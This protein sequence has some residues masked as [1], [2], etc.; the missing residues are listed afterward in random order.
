METPHVNPVQC[1]ENNWV[2]YLCSSP[3]P[4]NAVFVD[5]LVTGERPGIPSGSLK[6]PVHM[7]GW[8][9]G[10]RKCHFLFWAVEFQK[11]S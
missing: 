1:P 9:V 5:D 7:E 2:L 11:C 3:L 4:K 8:V 10:L 6:P